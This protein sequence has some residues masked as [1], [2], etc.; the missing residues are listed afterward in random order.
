MLAWTRVRVDKG[1]WGGL[2]Y[3]GEDRTNLD[4]NGGERRE[5][6]VTLGDFNDMMAESL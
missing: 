2:I 4:G 6:A 5:P 1:K 3:L